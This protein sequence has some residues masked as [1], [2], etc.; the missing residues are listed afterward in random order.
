MIVNIYFHLKKVKNDIKAGE[1]VYIKRQNYN[2]KSFNA[3]N[4]SNGTN[5]SNSSEINLSDDEYI[6]NTR[7]VTDFN[8]YLLSKSNKNRFVCFF[9]LNFN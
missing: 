2:F 7:T 1:N 9:G 3:K 8:G 5:S 4:D 6:P